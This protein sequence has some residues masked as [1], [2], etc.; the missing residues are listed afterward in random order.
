MNKFKRNLFVLVAVLACSIGIN[1]KIFTANADE[2]A[3]D[4]VTQ[5]TSVEIG[6][7]S[8]DSVWDSAIIEETESE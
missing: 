8:A 3:V 4:S 1:S 6:G 2:I 5:E 7:I